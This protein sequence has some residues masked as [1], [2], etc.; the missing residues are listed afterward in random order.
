MR[1]EGQGHDLRVSVGE[2]AVDDGVVRMAT[3]LPEARVEI[4]S[5]DV[6]GY[7]VVLKHHRLTEVASEGA[8]TVADAA[9][10]SR[11]V[12]WERTGEALATAVYE[13][14]RLPASARVDGPALVDLTD[15]TLVVGPG[16]HVDRDAVGDFQLFFKEA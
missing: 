3:Q 12:C 15:T 11:D 8:T 5:A 1:Y 10:P 7:G 14:L 2:G 6:Q 13:G 16:Q 9:K 4:V